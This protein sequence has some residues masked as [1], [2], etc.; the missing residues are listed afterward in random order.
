MRC[1]MP[2][3]LPN[4]RPVKRSGDNEGQ[5]LM[6]SLARGHTLVVF[7]RRFM[8]VCVCLCVPLSVHI[9]GYLNF[10]EPLSACR[11]PLMIALSFWHL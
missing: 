3:P 11:R 4:W 10:C 7:M 9:Q 5:L 2:C 8:C 1:R 6:S